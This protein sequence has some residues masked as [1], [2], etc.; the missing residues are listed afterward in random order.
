MC[1]VNDKFPL[2]TV[3]IPTYCRPQYVEIALK[4]VLDQTYKNIEIFVTDNSPDDRTE[5]LMKKYLDKY[6][7]IIYEHHP[8]YNE[9]DNWEC[10]M[11]YNNPKAEYVNWLMDDDI[12]LPNKI[13][14]MIDKFLRYEN[15]ALVTSY[16]QCIDENGNILPDYDTTIPITDKDAIYSGVIAGRGIIANMWNYI[17]E[18][19]TVLIKKSCM[20]NGTLGARANNDKYW[21]SD[22]PTW[23][24]CLEHGDLYYVVTPLSQ[25]R[26]HSEQVQCN[27]DFCGR[28]LC[29]WAIEYLY[30]INNLKFIKQASDLSLGIERW[31]DE[32]EYYIDNVSS[33]GEYNYDIVNTLT[34]FAETLIKYKQNNIN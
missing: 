19:T 1:K 8:E 12:F 11:A 29:K 2:V 21:V 3:I 24:Q 34:K 10:G 23:L 20:K 25:F 22:F 14:Y 7:N 32:L 33:T 30:E 4:S 6:S 17:G 31:F 26:V 9:M 15:L 13:E 28:A 16:R 5:I 18:P 27:M